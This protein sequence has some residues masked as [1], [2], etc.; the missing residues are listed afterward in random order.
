VVKDVAP[1]LGHG[2]DQGL[3]VLL[4]FK[5]GGQVAPYFCRKGQQRGVFP[6]R[7]LLSQ[8]FHL[9]VGKR[10]FFAPG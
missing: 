9:V 7:L 1:E 5:E 8:A 10:L 4:V 3:I 6:G 2:Q